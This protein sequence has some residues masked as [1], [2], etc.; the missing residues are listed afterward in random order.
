MNL[1]G[2]LDAQLYAVRIADG[3]FED[4]FYFLIGI[5]ADLEPTISPKE[6]K[7]ADKSSNSSVR[8]CLVPRPHAVVF[9]FYGL[10]PSIWKHASVPKRLLPEPVTPTTTAD[11]PFWS[12]PR[13]R[14]PSPQHLLSSQQVY[15]RRSSAIYRIAHA[16]QQTSSS[17]RYARS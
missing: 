8:L 14:S 11:A 3:H 1:E 2:L 5:I 6:E 17:I 15:D 12:I 16:A 4:I 9:L 13:R 7:R 10:P